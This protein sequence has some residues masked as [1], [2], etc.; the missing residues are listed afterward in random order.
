MSV[1]T[2][3]N[4]PTLEHCRCQFFCCSCHFQF[5]PKHIINTFVK[6]CK[7][8]PRSLYIPHECEIKGSHW[9]MLWNLHMLLQPQTVLVVHHNFFSS[10]SLLNFLNIKTSVIPPNKKILVF[11]LITLEKY[12]LMY[13]DWLKDDFCFFIG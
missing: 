12:L 13:T 1:F 5:P 11:L 3:T 10:M 6:Y 8:I 7:L 2:G 9:P 4:K